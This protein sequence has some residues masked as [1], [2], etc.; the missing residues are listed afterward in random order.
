[1]VIWRLYLFGQRQFCQKPQHVV[2]A[3]VP[4]TQ[5]IVGKPKSGA[6]Q[7]GSHD[8][9]GLC[10]SPGSFLG[11]TNQRNESKRKDQRETYFQFS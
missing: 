2:L 10:E 3:R 4:A 8:L 5:N 6:V 9:I 7:L 1:M 11:A